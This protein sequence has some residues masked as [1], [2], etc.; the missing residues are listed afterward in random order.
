MVMRKNVA[1]DSSSQIVR[2]ASVCVCV[3]AENFASCQS[4]P[5]RDISLDPCELE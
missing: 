1:V 5:D 4:L 3:L 2:N